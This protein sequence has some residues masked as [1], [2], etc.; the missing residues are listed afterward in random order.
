[1][2][3]RDRVDERGVHGKRTDFTARRAGAMVR[4][5]PPV[6]TYI[7]LAACASLLVFGFWLEGRK[8]EHRLAKARRWSWA[9]QIAAVAA[10][11]FVLRPG[12][13]ADAPKDDI[14]A[15]RAAG[16]PIF[17]DFYSNY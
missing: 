8:D 12:R 17:V 15:A 11:Y 10:A 1:M 13:G 5:M 3:R 7:L 14:A 4:A 6:L 16:A 2:D 9:L